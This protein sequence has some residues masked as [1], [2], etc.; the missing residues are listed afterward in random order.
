MDI[1]AIATI[2]SPIISTIAI[3]VALYISKKSTKDLKKQNQT[4]RCATEAE[5]KQIRILAHTLMIGQ[6]YNFEYAN[7]NNASQKNEIANSISI[8]LERYEQIRDYTI[9]ADNIDVKQINKH[10]TE[11]AEIYTLLENARNNLVK[12]QNENN[13]I[14][15]ALESLKKPIDAFCKN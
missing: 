15:K 12:I 10:F 1:Q 4:I 11:M 13:A 8:I 7:Q 5:I 2:I 14:S 9:N 6:I 3:V